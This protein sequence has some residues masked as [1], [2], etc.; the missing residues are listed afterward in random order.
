MAVVVGLIGA[1]AAVEVLKEADFAVVVE[2]SAIT[3][4]QTRGAAFR[5]EGIFLKSVQFSE[6][7]QSRKSLDLSLPC[8]E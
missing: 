2:P 1:G 7:G 5:G 8:A 3:G 6:A 4:A